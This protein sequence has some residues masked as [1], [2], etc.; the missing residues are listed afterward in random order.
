MGRLEEFQKQ[1]TQPPENAKG[2]TRWWW[3]GA[4]VNREEISYELDQMRQAGIGGVELQILYP[5]VPDNRKK[6]VQNLPYGSPEFYQILDYTAEECEKR[7]MTFDVT[8]GSSW[9][10]GGPVIDTEQAMECVMPYQIDVHGP[11]TFSLDLTNYVTG[12]VVA[13]CL[14][15]MEHCVM[16]PD[17][18]RDIMDAVRV[19]ELFGWPWG[20]AIDPIEVPPGDWKIVLFVVHLHRNLVGKPAPNAGGYVLDHCNAQALDCFLENMVQPILDKVGREHIRTLFCDSIEVEGHNWTSLLLEEFEKRRGYSLKPYIYGLWGNL[21]EISEDVRYDY[22]CTM[23]ELTLEN[24]FDRFTDFCHKN[25][26]LSRIQAHG[27][28]GDILRAYAAA[29]IPEGE[30]FGSCDHLWV[31]TIHRKLAVSAAHLYGKPVVSNE[32]FTWLTKP[33]FTETPEDLKLAADVVFADG[34]NMIVNHGYSY[35]PPD[36]GKY[37]CPFYASS[38]INHTTPWW[39]YYSHVGQYIQRASALLRRGKPVSRVLFYLP[40]AD[41]WSENLMSDLHLALKLEQQIGA[42]TGN[43]LHEAGYEFDYVNDEILTESAELRGNTFRIQENDYEAVLL[44]GCTR[45]PEQTAE[46]LCRFAKNGGIL[47]SAEQIPDKGCG[48][49]NREAK[50]QQVKE[51]MEEAFK[52]PKARVVSDRTTALVAALSE[53]LRPDVSMERRETVGF[54]HRQEGN[55]HLYFLP[56]ISKQETVTTI[57]FSG[58]REK[59]AVVDL[60]TGNIC[61]PRKIRYTEDGCQMELC[62]ASCQS[63]VVLFSD[64]LE[65]SV[66]V[67]LPKEQAYGKL[68][69]RNCRLRIPETGKEFP[70]AKP[71]TWKNIPELR[72]FAGKGEYLLEFSSEKPAEQVL[73]QLKTLSCCCTVWVNDILCGEIWKHP[74]Q[75]DITKGWRLGNNQ[76]RIEV[77]SVPYHE[78]IG[79]GF[80]IPEISASLPEWPYYGKVLENLWHK[81]V[82]FL[83]E[84]QSS[85][86]ILPPGIGEAVVIERFS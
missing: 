21:G 75:L 65:Q 56:N 42:E 84:Q 18:V 46:I 76:V 25:Q 77:V 47:I 26:V 60:E 62:F 32:T 80:D 2:Y 27:T 74:C 39:P 1:I 16:E 17:S 70:L 24:F 48:L 57:L 15:K 78:I 20:Y 43:F 66:A 79:P 37:G 38:H 83:P 53:F 72:Y 63:V 6:G 81:R 49:L 64:E 8:P 45:L 22:F 23:S 58:R 73:L 3:Y 68:F 4:A 9:P 33:R 10:Y 14:G 69:P 5:V 13:A 12:T 59:T 55:E 52:Q 50:A 61:A 85:L 44:V 28:W 11:C 35:V 31:N 71:E 30:T 51:R 36:T 41:V 82:N 19:T 40:Q 34:C 29:D 54:V 86:D 67:S 7:G